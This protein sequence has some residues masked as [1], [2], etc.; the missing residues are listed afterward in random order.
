MTFSGWLSDPFEWLSDLQLGDEKVTKNHRDYFVFRGSNVFRQV[1]KRPVPSSL[2]KVW[3]G[4]KR[5]SDQF[6][7]PPGPPWLEDGLPV[8]VTS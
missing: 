7:Q 6:G 5:S 2:P 3:S 8:D 4:T 1:F